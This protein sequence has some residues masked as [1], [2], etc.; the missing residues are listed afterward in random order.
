MAAEEQPAAVEVAAEQVN[1]D[2][3]DE[4][5]HNYDGGYHSSTQTVLCS[6]TDP[7]AAWRKRDIPLK[8][9]NKHLN[10]VFRLHG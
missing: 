4:D 3:N 5:D 1:G 6:C 7:G 10:T 9:S 2:E 8:F